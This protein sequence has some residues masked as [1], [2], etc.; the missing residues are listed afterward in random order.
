M[1]NSSLHNLFQL[2]LIYIFIV[3][4]LLVLQILYLKNFAHTWFEKIDILSCK[5]KSLYSRAI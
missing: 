1:F 4:C 2:K 5:Y 3:K